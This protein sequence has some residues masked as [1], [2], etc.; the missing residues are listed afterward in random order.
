MVGDIDGLAAQLV[1]LS[2]PHQ[3][4]ADL[5]GGRFHSGVLAATTPHTTASGRETA[6][7]NVFDSAGPNL[8]DPLD[9]PHQGPPGTFPMPATFIRVDHPVPG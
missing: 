6:G 1:D 5:Q 4:L 8:A 2:Q 9:G 7:V 3:R